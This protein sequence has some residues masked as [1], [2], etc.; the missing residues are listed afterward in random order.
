MAREHGQALHD[1]INRLPRSFRSAVVLCYME[2]LTVDEA[3]RRLRWPAG[4][5]RSRIARARDKLR[6]ALTRRGIVLPT[7]GLAAVLAP[8]P[9]SAS[10]SSL[11]CETTTRAAI[12]FAARQSATAFVS[13]STGPLAQDV[14]RSMALKKLR[15]LAST[16]LAM[17]IVSAGTGHLTHAPAMN[18]GSRTTPAGWQQPIA[19]RLENEPQPTATPE[20]AAGRMTVSGRVLDP[21]GKPMARVPVD[22]LRTLP[23][24]ALGGSRHRGRI[25]S[26]SSAAAPDRRQTADLSLMPRTWIARFFEVYALA[27]SP[28]FGLNWSPLNA[29]SSEPSAEIRFRPEQVI[30]GTLV[31]VSGQLG[32]AGRRGSRPQMVRRALHNRPNRWHSLLG[33]SC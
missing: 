28:G 1:E 21:D 14:L 10:V 30:R 15:F 17:G 8:R 2:G 9:A 27:A 13:A 18:D 3:A 12:A 20:P 31:D 5:V 33:S 29:D 6:R 19:V 32:L 26:S 24:G 25:R 22:V 4:T 11:L 16:L 7:A 23:P